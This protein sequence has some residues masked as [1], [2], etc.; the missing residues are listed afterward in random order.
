MKEK[1]SK[2]ERKKS[3][4]LRKEGQDKA[5]PH[6]PK[7]LGEKIK[8]EEEEWIYGVHPVEEL[9]LNRPE[10]IEELLVLEHGGKAIH[11]VAKEAIKSGILVK[12]RP[13]NFFDRLLEGKNHQ[14]VIAKTKSFEYT[15]FDEILTDEAKGVL[16]FL[17]GVLDPGNLGALIRSAR[18]FGARGIILNERGGCHITPAVIRASSGAVNLLPIAKIRNPSLAIK[19][20]K[21]RGWWI[22]GMATKGEFIQRFD[23]DRPT[24]FLLGEEGRGLKPSIEKQCDALLGI[25]MSEEWDSLN[26]AHAGTIALYEWQRQQLK[27]MGNFS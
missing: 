17:I 20:M 3:K 1:H 5:K 8:M 23:L 18:A 10:E 7:N 14:G 9:I 25:P 12:Y 6:S 11:R 26:V 27:K 22:I 4:N 2:Q 15:N 16:L 21:E 24:V 13:R 19:R